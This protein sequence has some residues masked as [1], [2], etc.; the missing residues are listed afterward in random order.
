MS[1]IHFPGSRQYGSIG[2]IENKAELGEA[3]AADIV[4]VMGTKEQCAAAAEVLQVSTE[5]P[6]RNGPS[7]RGGSSDLPSRTLSIPIKYHH[8]IADQPNLIRS[9][10]SAGGFI[11]IPSPAPPRPNTTKPASNGDTNGTSLAAK[12]ARIDLDGDEESSGASEG[13]WVIQPNYEGSAEGDAD[14]SVR[15]KEED[16]DKAVAILEEAVEKAKAATHG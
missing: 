10:R 5:R 16:L 1:S 4:K 9:I 15:A 6:A 11:T 14:W 7:G 2:D 13:E 3:E 12:A 8:A